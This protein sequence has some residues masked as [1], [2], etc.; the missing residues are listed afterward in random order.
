MS[1]WL[2]LS[3]RLDSEVLFAKYTQHLLN[4]PK[5]VLNLRTVCNDYIEHSKLFMIVMFIVNLW[6][7]RYIATESGA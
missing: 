4:S 2:E 7:W 3:D 5:C 6:L 1:W